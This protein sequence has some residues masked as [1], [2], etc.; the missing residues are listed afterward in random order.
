MDRTEGGYFDNIFLPQ[1][2]D[3]RIIS[4]MTCNTAAGRKMPNKCNKRTDL[5]TIS[6][7]TVS[8]LL[9][10]DSKLFVWKT[11]ILLK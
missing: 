5:Y 3:K 11:K 4:V 8:V 9:L 10:L 2:V 7:L 1:V 6:S